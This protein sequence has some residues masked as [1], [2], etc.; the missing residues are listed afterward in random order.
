MTDEEWKRSGKKGAESP[1]PLPAREEHAKR[2]S[3]GGGGELQSGA[4]AEVARHRLRLASLPPHRLRLRLPPPLLRPAAVRPHPLRSRLPRCPSPRS[5]PAPRHEGQ[6]LSAKNEESE[7][8]K[9]PSRMTTPRNHE[10]GSTNAR[11]LILIE[12]RIGYGKSIPRY[13]KA[14]PR[15]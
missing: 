13:W 6:L 9:K 7:R 5:L 4:P 10:V 12:F 14:C 2:S 8:S 11:T 3:G 15:S 1:G